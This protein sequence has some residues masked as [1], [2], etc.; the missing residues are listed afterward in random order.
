[1]PTD[2]RDRGRIALVTSG[3]HAHLDEDLAP[4]VEALAA[5]EVSAEVVDWHDEGFDWSSVDLAV[6]RSP[7]DYTWQLDAFLEFAAR[8]DAATTLANPL[9]VLRWNT[10]K[11]YL[12]ELAQ[13]DVPVV[14]TEWL[15]PGDEINLPAD[16]E[17]VIKPA[18]SAGSR[19]AGRFDLSDAAQRELAGKHTR[20]LLDRG[21]TA[22]VQPYFDA[23]DTAGETALLFMAGHFSHA[24]RKAPLLTGP[25]TAVDG[26]FRFEE[27]TPR[28]AS[29]TELDTAE[30][31]LAAIPAER[32]DELLYARVDLI[33]AADG[34]PVLLELE[35]AEPSLFLARDNGAAARFAAAIGT[36]LDRVLKTG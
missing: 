15:E 18:V 30:A 28:Q 29:K 32:A 27:I 20:G 22:M 19:D 36:H 1:M 12:R 13:A 14:P 16:G 25:D 5:L 9:A 35:L 23:V 21:L 4:I 10:D 3:D 31:V 8:V 7:W 34:Q 6:I 11:R 2:N 33:P 26:L 17:Y 24:I